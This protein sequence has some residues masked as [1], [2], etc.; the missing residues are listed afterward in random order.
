[1]QRRSMGF[2][3]AALLAACGPERN[4]AVY[5]TPIQGPDGG[6]SAL[7]VDVTLKSA[8][9][10]AVR[11]TANGEVF[12]APEGPVSRRC[13]DFS[14][15]E[16]ATAHVLA[17]NG[18]FDAGLRVHAELWQGTCATRGAYLADALYPV[19]QPGANPGTPGAGGGGGATGVDE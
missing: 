8:F 6:V 16:H 10:A 7:A 3:L 14:G 13:F 18:T 5:L 17:S 15:T 9:D 12:V 2:I 4:N 1:M 19:G 11:V